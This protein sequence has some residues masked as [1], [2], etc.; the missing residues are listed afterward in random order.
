MGVEDMDIEKKVEEAMKKGEVPT[1]RPVRQII[2]FISENITENESILDVGC[3]DNFVKKFFPNTTGL[4]IEREVHPE[5]IGDAHYLPLE[6]NSFDWVVAISVIEHLENPA[7]AVREMIRVA[8]KGVLLWTDLNQTDMDASP[9]HKYCWTPK[10][11]GQFLSM[12]K[13]KTRAEVWR[14]FALVGIIEKEKVKRGCLNKAKE[15][16]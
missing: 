5:V 11:F 13:H 8:K 15:V 14:N 2:Q 7:I 4:D 16:N 12:F 3:G 10:I 9:D 6:D 1:D